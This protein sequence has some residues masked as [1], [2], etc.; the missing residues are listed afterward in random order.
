MCSGEYESLKA[1]VY[2]ND[3]NKEKECQ[4]FLEHV[5]KLLLGQYM[6]KF[7]SITFTRFE[8]ESRLTSGDNDVLQGFSVRDDTGRTVNHLI[9]WEVKAPQCSPFKI[10]T[11]NRAA[12]TSELIEVENQLLHYFHDVKSSS[13]IKDEFEITNEDNIHIGGIIIG[14]EDNLIVG[15]NQFTLTD[16]R[17]LAL[18]R[19]AKGYREKYFWDPY[20]DIKLWDSVLANLCPTTTQT[21][22]PEGDPDSMALSLAGN[23][24]LAPSEPVT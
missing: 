21:I 20:I 4:P 12:P 24:E 17:R 3:G 7:D 23:I 10:T 1:L 9:V 15:G 11:K 2:S 13:A 16:E 18:Y 8:R 5:P 14:R 22:V 6:S 19:R